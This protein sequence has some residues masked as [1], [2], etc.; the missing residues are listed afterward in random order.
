M[1]IVVRD[2]FQAKYGKGG[3]LAALFKES[4]EKWRTKYATRILT[5]ASGPFFTVVTETEFESLAEWEKEMS[6]TFTLPDF[7]DW[8]ERMT[9][10]VDS[11]SR[12][13][14]NIEA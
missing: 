13:F 9:S 11:G 12:E 14:Y 4:Q 8:F 10:L 7:N 6:Q 3:D 1:M 5:D 2:V